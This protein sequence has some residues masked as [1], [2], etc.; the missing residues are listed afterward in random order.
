MRLLYVIISY[1]LIC[2]DYT[3][4]SF[5]S[6]DVAGRT[7]VLTDGIRYGEAGRRRTEEI[8]QMALQLL[9]EAG[10]AQLFSGDGLREEF[11]R[12]VSEYRA[13]I[14]GEHFAKVEPLKTLFSTASVFEAMAYA[15]ALVR[16]DGAPTEQKAL[17]GLLCDLVK[18]DRRN[19]I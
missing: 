15:K 12:Q 3:S 13:E 4:R 7:A 6:L 8:V 16:P 19:V 1:L 14:L 2:L 5:V 11:D 17:I 18:H 10:K 9:A